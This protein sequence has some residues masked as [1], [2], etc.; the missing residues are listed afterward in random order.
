M[1]FTMEFPSDIDI[2]QH[3]GASYSRWWIVVAAV[4]A[5][6][7]IFLLLGTADPIGYA[8]DE[9]Y[10]FSA[11]RTNYGWFVNLKDNILAGTPAKSFS[12]NTIRRY[13][14]NNHE[15]P[16][17]CKIM[18]GFHNS[19]WEKTL[20]IMNPGTSFRMS[21]ML[22]AGLALFIIFMIGLHFFGPGAAL[23]ATLM[24]AFMPRVFFHAHLNTYDMPNVFF[25]L[26]TM[27]LFWKGLTRPGYLILT[28][29][30]WG[31]AMSARNAAF[32]IPVAMFLV[33]LRSPLMKEFLR[34]FTRIGQGIKAF[35]LKRWLV[36]LVWIA[37]LGAAAFMQFNPD[38]RA[39]SWGLV[40]MQ[41]VAFALPVIF[42]ITT[43]IGDTKRS[44]RPIKSTW[45]GWLLMASSLCMLG[46]SIVYGDVQTPFNVLLLTAW[47]YL[48]GYI[49]WY[50]TRHG[51]SMPAWARP[52]VAPIVLG[53]LTFFIVWP[54][55]YHDTW[56]RLGAFFARHLDP[57]AWQT[58]YFGDMITNPPPYPSSY[59][60]VMWFFTIP[61]LFMFIAAIG[62]TIVIIRGRKSRKD[63]KHR[64]MS[65]GLSAD[66]KMRQ[67]KQSSFARGWLLLVCLAIPPL[68]IAMPSTPVYGGTKHFLHALPF[69]SLIAS[70]GFIWLGKQLLGLLPENLGLKAK[71]TILAVF[72][73]FLLMPGIY[74]TASGYQ[75]G[76]GFYNEIMGGIIAAPEVGMQQS[77]WAY[78]TRA[79]LPWLNE[80]VPQNGSVAWNNL[81]WDCFDM[82]KREGKL[83]KDIR[84]APNTDLADFYVTTVW[85]MFLD[86]TFEVETSYQARGIVA[87]D[88]IFGLPMVI[89]HQNMKRI[90]TPIKTPWE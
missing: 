80:H 90:K 40:A 7:Y 16:S 53:P 39:T 47:L 48:A 23:F 71:Q 70:V 19:L 34:S 26:L 42:G 3:Q 35:G 5:L 28:G 33:Y 27:G 84:M 60:F 77:F 10:Y 8:K 18:Q 29:I 44:E 24:F 85:Q 81:P 20:G 13:W 25:W 64:I 4:L 15:H 89:V 54:W 12:N 2:K 72:G 14:D 50:Y 22:Q 51:I 59:P 62:A 75:Y 37:V 21:T 58:M 67:W 87:Q 52:I 83:R 41:I 43:L 11:S 69:M 9:G 86:G 56:S 65:S 30:A 61:M 63:L 88:D 79:I 66:A 73:L 82:Y 31:L 46:I 45:F 32:F 38:F 78:Q 76:L 17:F 1:S 6:A 49:C 74:G 36:T 68:V 57:P 55:L